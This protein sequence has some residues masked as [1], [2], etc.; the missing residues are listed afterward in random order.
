MS[1]FDS[2][3]SQTGKNPEKYKFIEWDEYPKSLYVWVDG[4]CIKKLSQTKIDNIINSENIIPPNS[5]NRMFSCAERRLV[6][7]YKELESQ[8]KDL[9]IISK[10]TPCYMCERVLEYKNIKYVSFETYTQTNANIQKEL[11]FFANKIY[12]LNK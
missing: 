5:Y 10:K 7:K 11:D 8:N 9:I 3:L 2:K 1:V 4:I 12:F 6:H